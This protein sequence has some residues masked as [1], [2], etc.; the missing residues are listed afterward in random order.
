MQATVATVIALANPDLRE[1]LQAVLCA[2]G[3]VARIPGNLDDLTRFLGNCAAGAGHHRCVLVIDEAFIFPHVYEECARIQAVSQLPLTV[4]LLVEPRTRT[5]WDWHG[6]DQI[7]R[8]PMGAKE[9]ACR[10]VG[11]LAALS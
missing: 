8:L 3:V 4:L 9:I 6:V 1:R 5:R 11:S 10:V 2:E 7:L